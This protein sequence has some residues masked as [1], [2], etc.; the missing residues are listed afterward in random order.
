M[1]FELYRSIFKTLEN[2]KVMNLILNNLDESIITLKPDSGIAYKNQQGANIINLI[3][4]ECS[5][6]DKVDLD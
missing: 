5:H 4:R 1:K 6:H 3:E 2:E